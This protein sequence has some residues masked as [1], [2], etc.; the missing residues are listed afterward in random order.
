MLPLIFKTDITV[1]SRKDNATKWLL[2]RILIKHPFHCDRQKNPNDGNKHLHRST[3]KNQ[4]TVT[5]KFY[6]IM[7]F[8]HLMKNEL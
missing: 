2:L 7:Y 3:I 5:K 6:Q 4:F 1:Y 8:T